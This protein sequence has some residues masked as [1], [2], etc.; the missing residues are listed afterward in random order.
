MSDRLLSSLERLLWSLRAS[1]P[2]VAD[3][4]SY[5][6]G[7][8]DPFAQSLPSVVSLVRWSPIK[9][10]I[11]CGLVSCLLFVF[12]VGVPWLPSLF[13]SGVRPSLF[14]IDFSRSRPSWSFLEAPLL[15]ATIELSLS[16]EDV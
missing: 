14:W 10:E 13:S 16:V 2:A 1:A 3:L 6:V 9:S 4:V 8:F 11:D 15:S 5:P 7:D 12:G